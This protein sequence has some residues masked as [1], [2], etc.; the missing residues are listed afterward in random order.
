MSTSL[1]RARPGTIAPPRLSNFPIH[2]VVVSALA[3]VLSFVSIGE[4]LSNNIWPI[5]LLAIGVA[6]VGVPHGALDHWYGWAVL[7]P[8]FGRWWPLLF[9]GGYGVVMCCVVVG[10]IFL[11]T[12]MLLVFLGLSALH[13]GYED[14]EGIDLVPWIR[15]IVALCVGG[16]VIWIPYHYQTKHIQGIFA[17]IAPQSHV[18]AFVSST[19]LAL[20]LGGVL[21]FYVFALVINS[22]RKRK[23]N[24]MYEAVRILG[25]GTM[26]MIAPPLVSFLVYFCA[27]HSIRGL[28]HLAESMAPGRT[29]KGWKLLVRRALP[30][31]LLTLVFAAMGSWF[32]WRADTFGPNV[33][34]IVFL[35]LS[36][37]AIP[38][39]LLHFGC[40][41]VLRVNPFVHAQVQTGGN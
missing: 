41:Q 1:K 3:L 24:S 21:V 35:G 19:W 14:L 5:V 11:P 8:R 32:L 36:V 10:W 16:M 23:Q 2:H 4:S 18:D 7:H 38:H 6:F 22:A 9:F 26:F 29:V 17:W 15:P 28:I 20:M 40:E 30:L 12:A 37:I 39:L 25:F 31:T 27:W 33:V 13:F 34:Q